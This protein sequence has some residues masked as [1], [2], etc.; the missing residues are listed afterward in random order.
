MRSGFTLLELVLVMMIACIV[1]AVA[2]PRL[3]GWSHGADMTNTADQI[4]ML[5]R[6]AQ[7]HAV[8]QATT[9]RVEFDNAAPPHFWLSVQQGSGYSDA[10][11]FLEVNDSFGAKYKMPEG[12]QFELRKAAV[13]S[14]AQNSAANS[15]DF[16]PTGRTQPA[17]LTLRNSLEY[18][19]VIEST[20]PTESFHVV[21]GQTQ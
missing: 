3:R 1:M 20:T 4:L 6:Y 5:M 15:I 17:T 11:N 16:Y 21:T 12:V 7:S 10:S 9:Y 14:A 19:V 2:A 18:T 8:T 13:A